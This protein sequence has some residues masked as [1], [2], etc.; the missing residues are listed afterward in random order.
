MEKHRKAIDGDK[1]D[2]ANVITHVRACL[3][4]ELPHTDPEAALVWIPSQV[5]VKWVQMVK[6]RFDDWQA[7]TW[8]KMLP[9]R[10]FRLPAPES[11]QRL[12]VVGAGV[13]PDDQ[14]PPVF[15]EYRPD[16]KGKK[17]RNG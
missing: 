1:E 6:P 12:L 14:P 7:S 4:E 15:I 3:R 5:L 11:G 2:L 13:D 17:G 8:L 10:A 9:A 16:T